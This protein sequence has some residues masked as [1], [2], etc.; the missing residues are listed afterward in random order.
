LFSLSENARLRSVEEINAYADFVP[1]QVVDA[2]LQLDCSQRLQL[3]GGDFNAEISEYSLKKLVENES[4]CIDQNYHS[5][6]TIPSI[7][8]EEEEGMWL[9][10]WCHKTSRN[11]SSIADGFTFPSHI[12]EKRIDYLLY[13]HLTTSQCP[14]PDIK[15]QIREIR[16][17]GR[18]PLAKSDEQRVQDIDIDT[19]GNVIAGSQRKEPDLLD[20]DGP[21]WASDHYGLMAVLEISPIHTL[22]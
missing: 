15:L 7:N 8:S 20:P 3:F 14:A 21:V 17:L 5:S 18:R 13:R 6:Q 9:D 16:I 1:V 4:Q 12:P 2:G 11:D 22:P 19:Y 10:L